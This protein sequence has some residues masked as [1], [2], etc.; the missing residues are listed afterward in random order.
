M[1]AGGGMGAQEVILLT[2]MPPFWLSLARARS[3]A[4]W[5]SRF[6][7]GPEGTTSQWSLTEAVIPWREKPQIELTP[8]MPG[9]W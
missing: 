1:L 4:F 2:P 8:V 5:V 6:A 9:M 7:E 3:R